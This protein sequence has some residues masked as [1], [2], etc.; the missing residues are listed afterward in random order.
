MITTT[1]PCVVF[2]H[3]LPQATYVPI[4]DCQARA[5]STTAHA[6]KYACSF[7]EATPKCTTDKN[8]PLITCTECNRD[9]LDDRCYINH[10]LPNGRGK[11]SVCEAR[12][13][14][15]ICQVGYRSRDE[16]FC[17][18]HYCKIC[19]KY[20]TNTHQCH[21]PVYETKSRDEQNI[22]YVFL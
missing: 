11:T 3:A 7:C 5:S 21:M 13:K 1:T 9:F 6:C 15:H 14:C 16:H 17:G 8:A 10:I 2:R 19:E 20:E 12:K 4:P 22:L 18:I